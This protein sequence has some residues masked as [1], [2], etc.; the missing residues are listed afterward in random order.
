LRKTDRDAKRE[1]VLKKEGAQ[2]KK[3]NSPSRSKGVT[4][5]L[6][7]SV[8]TQRGGDK[9]K[10]FKKKAIGGAALNFSKQAVNHKRKK[11]AH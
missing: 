6:K 3:A 11:V 10:K 5:K 2:I 1:G 8:D 7:K 4:C 9:P